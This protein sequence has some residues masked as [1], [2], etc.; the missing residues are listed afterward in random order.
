MDLIPNYRYYVNLIFTDCGCNLYSLIFCI[1]FVE[2]KSF[3]IISRNAGFALQFLISFHYIIVRFRIAVLD[4]ADEASFFE[5][6]KSVLA[7]RFENGD[8]AYIKE[9]GAPAPPLVETNAG[10]IHFHSIAG[11]D[12]MRKQLPAMWCAN[13]VD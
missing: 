13:E 6:E 11:H 10:G 12:R 2:I 7:G 1:I 3:I 5:V 9:H 8:Y 4:P